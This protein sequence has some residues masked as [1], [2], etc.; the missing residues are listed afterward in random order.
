[1]NKYIYTKKPSI[2][3]KKNEARGQARMIIIETESLTSTFL[4]FYIC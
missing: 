2:K 1:M 4:K 3:K